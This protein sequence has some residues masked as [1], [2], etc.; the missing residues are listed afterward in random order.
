MRIGT[1]VTLPTVLNQEQVETQAL[2]SNL[3]PVW[4]F[5]ASLTGLPFAIVT[6]TFPGTLVAPQ[7]CALVWK[8]MG[9]P[10]EGAAPVTL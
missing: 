5:S 1:D 4:I 6:Q 10:P 8:L 7:N 9:I 2:L 3:V